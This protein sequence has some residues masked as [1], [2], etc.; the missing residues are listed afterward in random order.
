L[1]GSHL[2]KRGLPGCLIGEVICD[3]DTCAFTLTSS[4]AMS[5]DSDGSLSALFASIAE[6]A[7][8]DSVPTDDAGA[9]SANYLLSGIREIP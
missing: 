8:L 6:Y 5:A 7:M 4:C 1:V 9:W 2:S 3:D